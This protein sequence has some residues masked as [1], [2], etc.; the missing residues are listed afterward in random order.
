MTPKYIQSEIE[1][2]CH[3]GQRIRAIQRYRETVGGSLKEAKN[4]VDFYI[5]GGCW[6][7]SVRWD[8]TVPA[9]KSDPMAVVAQL[10]AN[11]QKIKAIK[12]YR[13]MTGAG[14][15]EAKQAVEE[16]V[17]SVSEPRSDTST[18]SNVLDR[19]HIE[20]LLNRGQKIQAIQYYRETT[21]AGLKDS[22]HAIEGLIKPQGWSNN[23]LDSSVSLAN[24]RKLCAD[25]M[26]I[27]AIKAYREYSGASLKESKQAIDTYIT[28][29]RG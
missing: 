8:S 4:A 11:G 5:K 2:L 25:D 14:L 26:R 23:P 22:K 7:Q 12:A 10:C 15:K 20:S 9:P 1:E 16:Y 24:I 21:G 27:K 29:R 6:P 13:D 19:E 28:H 3:N 17:R 18:T